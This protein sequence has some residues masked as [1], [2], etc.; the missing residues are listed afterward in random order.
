M[1]ERSLKQLQLILKN[2]DEGAWSRLEPFHLSVFRSLYARR[3]NYSFLHILA[4]FWDSQKHVFRFNMVELCPLPEEFEAILGSRLDSSRLIVVPSAQTPDLHIIHYQMARMF[5]LAPQLSL[6]YIFGNE[7]S[8]SSLMEAVTSIDVKE[9]RWPR[10]LASCIY[11][12]FLLVSLSGNC[13]AKLLHIIDQV[14]DGLNPFLLI[15]AETITGLDNFTSTRRFSGS[16]ILLEVCS[17]LF[18]HQIIS[19]IF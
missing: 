12:Q 15:L 17:F 5:N 14:E 16:P 9:T 4:Q 7:I 8:L 19:V 3:I 10:M 1:F 18:L 6:Q 11:A 13:D 2:I